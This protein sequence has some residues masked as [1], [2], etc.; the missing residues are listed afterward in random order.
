[1]EFNDTGIDFAIGLPMLLF[2]FFM[3]PL[4]VAFVRGFFK[5]FILR[6]W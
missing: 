4:L 2:T 3:L 6:N 5:N 1:M